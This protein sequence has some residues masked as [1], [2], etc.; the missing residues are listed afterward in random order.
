M[1]GSVTSSVPLIR[2]SIHSFPSFL[3]SFLPSFSSF[4]SFFISSSLY[5]LKSVKYSPDCKSVTKFACHTICAL[6]VTFRACNERC[7]QLQYGWTWLMDLKCRTLAY[8][9]RTGAVQSGFY[10]LWKYVY[11]YYYYYYYCCCPV[12]KLRA[13]SDTQTVYPQWPHTDPH[14]RP[15]RKFRT[16]IIKYAA[17]PDILTG[18]L[19]FSSFP[20]GKCRDII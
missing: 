6:N 1:G 2:S 17:T 7:T 4:S 12:L 14:Y 15:W 19:R 3:P 16:R 18:F 8:S 9:Q 10:F 20:P 5:S 11:Y 13:P